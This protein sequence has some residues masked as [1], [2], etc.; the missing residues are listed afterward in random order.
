MTARRTKQG[1]RGAGLRRRGAAAELRARPAAAME[2]SGGG[3]RRAGGAGVGAMGIGH[4]EESERRERWG[5]GARPLRAWVVAAEGNEEEGEIEGSVSARLGREWALGRPGCGWCRW[6]GAEN[7]LGRPSWAL[8]F[9][10]LLPIF[11]HLK[12]NRKRERKE[13]EGRGGL[14]AWG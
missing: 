1:G 9:L 6:A 3:D 11:F 5:S 10:S 14:W 4:E 2:D 12:Q 7:G 13:R 8:C